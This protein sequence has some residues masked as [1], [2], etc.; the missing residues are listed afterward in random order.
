MNNQN[1]PELGIDDER[2]DDLF[3]SIE[4]LLAAFF[5]EVLADEQGDEAIDHTD[6][7]IK[8]IEAES[9]VAMG[10]LAVILAALDARILSTSKTKDDEDAYE[11]KL[12]VPKGDLG[13]VMRQVMQNLDSDDLD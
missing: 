13:E 1:R 11:I 3:E 9:E 10:Y 5:T 7:D 6:E 12:T 8:D 4:K 2:F